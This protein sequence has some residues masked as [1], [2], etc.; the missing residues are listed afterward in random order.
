MTEQKTLNLAIPKKGRVSAGEDMF[1]HQAR[2]SADKTAKFARVR[3]ILGGYSAAELLEILIDK[4][5]D[6][7]YDGVAAN[8]DLLPKNHPNTNEKGSE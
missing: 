8:P 7:Y 2:I 3:E 1:N 6:A 4:A 5:V